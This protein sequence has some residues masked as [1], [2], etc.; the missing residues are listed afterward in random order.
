MQQTSALIVEDRKIAAL[1][2]VTNKTAAPWMAT[3]WM[4]VSCMAT[5]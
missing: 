4:I 1:Q 5:V 2:V 3:E